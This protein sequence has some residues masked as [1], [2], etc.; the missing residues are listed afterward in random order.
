MKLSSKWSKTFSRKGLA[1]LLAGAMTAFG[2]L[3]SAGTGNATEPAQ[4]DADVDVCSALAGDLQAGPTDALGL[5]GGVPPDPSGALDVL[6]GMLGTADALQA[7]EC[8][9]AIPPAAGTDPTECLTLNLDLVSTLLGVLSSL[10][11][12]T[13]G[14]LPD[15]TG[16][17][18]DVQDLLDTVTSLT[19]ADCLPTP[20]TPEVPV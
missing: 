8:L 7:T 15:V 12:L 11:E 2:L 6:W 13:G 20:E 16:V 3:A 5:L 17:I 18:S 9:P 19:D 14:G 10:T 4:P 1:A